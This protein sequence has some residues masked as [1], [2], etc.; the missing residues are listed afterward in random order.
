MIA[1]KRIR[2]FIEQSPRR[3][4]VASAVQRVGFQITSVISRSG[5]LWGFYLKPNRILKELLSTNRE[6]V[7]WVSEYPDFQARALSQAA[8]IVS[9]DQPRLCEDLAIIVTADRRTKAHVEEAATTQTQFVGFSLDEFAFFNSQEPQ[10]LL[11]A[12]QNQFYSK[13]LY[14]VSNAIT[15]RRAFFGRESIIKEMLATIR[16]DTSH[17]ALFGLRKMGKTS[18]L[19]RL[20]DE[21]RSNRSVIHVHLDLQ[22][23]DAIRPTAAYFLWSIGEQLHAGHSQVRAV[24]GFRL[25]GCHTRFPSHLDETDVFEEFDHD[26]RLALSETSKRI[27]FMID[28]IELMSPETPGSNW[29][30]AY[31]RLWRFFRGLDQTYPGRLRF[32]ISGT[33]PSCVEANSLG[34]RENPTYNYFT[35]KFL[36]PLTA[37]ASSELL[38]T[39]GHRIGLKWTQ[40]A[41]QRAHAVVGGHPFLLRLLGSAIHRSLQPRTTE[42]TVEDQNIVEIIPKFMS[43]ISSTLSQMVEVLEDEYSNEY[44]LL[45]LLATGRVGEFQELAAAF[46]EDVAH[47][48][49]YGLVPSP[50]AN[51]LAVELLQSWLQGRLRTR[52]SM[53][54]SLR[55][56]MLER[57]TILDNYTIDHVLGKPGGFGTVYA[58]RFGHEQQPVALKILKSASLAQ[59]QREADALKAISHPGIVKIIDSGKL[60]TG[61]V[62]LA[63]EHLNGHTLKQ[64]CTRA[65]RMTPEAGKQVLAGLLRALSALHSDEQRVA[66]LRA[67]G[68]LTVDEYAQ[69]EVAMHGYVH[70]DIKP[71]NIVLVQD[72]GPVLIDFGITVST[73]TS[74]TTVSATP[75]YLPPDGLP[76]R[77]VSDVDL[78]QLGLTMAQVL[79][80]FELEADKVEELLRMLSQEPLDRLG[81]VV[82][83]L[84]APTQ[85][86]RYT[87]AR[88]ALTSLETT[89]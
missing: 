41:T 18:L 33:N 5:E 25:F 13:D 46:P 26:I 45:N 86:Q 9:S 2:E 38:T 34:G 49:G 78:Y 60:S 48:V 73:L 39:L 79:C 89:A 72:R 43:E 44:D 61:Q 77:W 14:Y 21:L 62:Y 37:E 7:L 54:S 87:S 68:D 64:Y 67:K 32:L 10:A 65:T 29:G 81:E 59:L 85:L 74:T 66:E 20:I 75:G 35:K 88:E 30:G 52:A 4:V 22:R 31:V 42:L 36:P 11:Y 47:I 82:Q 6:V 50:N 53:S 80:G 23:I 40:Q 58:A 8:E 15:S 83:R 16:G 12:I 56:D 51:S 24:S 17:L 76:A 3:K 84:C 71:E 57:G 28:E 63:M 19:Y 69:L 70:R 27:L 55:D 1:N